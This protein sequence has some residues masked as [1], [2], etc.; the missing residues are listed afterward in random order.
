MENNSKF[1]MTIA[2]PNMDETTISQARKLFLAHKDAGVIK[3]GSF[4]QDV[5][6]CTDEYSNVNLDFRIKNYSDYSS[7]LHM[8][9][10]EFKNYLK[11]YIICQFG[12]LSLGG[13]QRIVHSVKA[14][15][16]KPVS[17]IS[18]AI[19][20]IN[21]NS[22]DKVGEFFSMLP[23][24]TRESEL[25]EILDELSDVY[26]KTAFSSS[27]QRSLAAFESYFR[28]N[29]ILDRFWKES[30]DINEKL[31]FFP[32]WMWW[33]VTGVLP[34]RP[35]EF[36]LTS[37]SCLKIVGGEHKLSVRRNNIKGSGKTKNYK[38]NYDYKSCEYTIPE[39]LAKEIQ[40]Y[41]DKTDKYASNDIK[42]LFIADPHYSLWDR[43]RPKNSRYYTYINLRTCLRYFYEKIVKER[44]GYNVI[45]DSENTVLNDEKDINYLHLGDTRHIALINLILEG[46]TPMITMM[47]AGH[48]NPDMSAHYYSNIA[49][50]VEC[51]TYRQYL[52]TISGNQFYRLSGPTERLSIK[53][54][55]TMSDG[56]RCFSTKYKN[57][58]FSDCEK[59]MGPSGE[60][61]FCK[62]CPFYRADEMSFQDSKAVYENRIV[63]DCNKLQEV[64]NAVRSGR[65]EPE[66]ITQSLL[67]LR[68]TEYSYQQFLLENRED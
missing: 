8:P 24:D 59:Q 2:I 52:K 12:N 3:T 27:C 9:I 40:W 16:A 5:W 51:R 25:D 47:L 64:V 50:L 53:E 20:E 28:F 29:D 33:K 68:N 35:R 62:T 19:D 48:D 49:K 6:Y 41:I 66:D 36:I 44:Y 65:G 42:T 13:L 37:R 38:I 32:V 43:N 67:R 56:G 55:S 61:G 58:D 45:Y 21:P 23:I 31:F 54:F 18:S 57:H 46:A 26:E 1:T 11:T 10:D 22:I 63:N 14:I 7:Y 34:L 17:D 4:D 60:L 15:V 39:S 30:K